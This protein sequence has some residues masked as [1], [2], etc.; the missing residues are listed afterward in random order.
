[1]TKAIRIRQHGGPAEMELV[2]IELPSPAS[3][4]VRVRH[5][6]IGVNFS[7]VNVRRGGFYL[8]HNPPFPLGLGNEAAGI[9]ESVGA[10]VTDFKPGDRVAYA[11]MRGQFYEDTGAYAQARNVPAERLVAI[12]PAVSNQQAAALLLKGSTASLIIN[13]VYKPGPDD[14]V[15]IHTAAAGVGSILVQWSKHL[16]ATVIGTV[17]SRKKADIAKR[18]GCDHVILY[19]ET[20][21]V[22]EVERIA[23][24][25]LTAVF[26]G[27]GKDTFLPSLPLLRQF[28]RAINYGNASGHVPPFN[29]M[30][31]A[32]KSISL[33]RVG[34]TG[35]IQDTASF[36]SVANE[37]FHLVQ[38]GTITVNIDRTYPLAET[39]QAHT[40]L[41]A[42][43]FSGSILLLP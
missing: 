20:D 5:T 30:L 35:H 12:P 27:V 17:G 25:G 40:D 4:E 7:D 2:D 11:G 28:G 39:P 1:M 19:R 16:G 34:V 13:G 14:I 32:I 3:D 9:V 36:R 41:E 23:P 43:K 21:F 6:A 22:T 18:I 10:A 31:L 15:L 38:D 8:N 26:D 24:K 42:G 29:L 33:S 37:L